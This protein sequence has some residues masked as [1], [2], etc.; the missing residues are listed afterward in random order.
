ME[1][2]HVRYFLAVAEEENF[3]RAAVR[4]GIGQPPLSQQIRALE[5]ELGTPLFRRLPHGAQLTEAGE[6]FLPEAR[7]MLA[8]A[9]RAVRAAQRAARGEVGQL[10][11]GFTGSAAFCPLVPAVVRAFRRAH[12]E[13]E[14]SLEEANTTT[15]LERLAGEELDAAFIRPGRAN[16]QG[17]RV[18]SLLE[19]P[20]WAVLPSS[21]PLAQAGAVALAALAREPFVLFP[22]SAGAS[23]FDEVLSACQRAGFEP[24]LVQEVSQLASVG[25][26][27]AAELGVSVVPASMAQVRVP[28]VEYLPLVGDAPVARLALATRLDEDSGGVR[29]FVTL[30]EAEGRRGPG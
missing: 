8:Q 21:H 1:L 18:Y 15:L 20:M 26:L 3:T 24:N 22:R 5:R 28:G 14:F 30:A 7:A 11:V 19:E 4:V 27:V 13:V 6:A 25:N 17:V 10:R 12:P 23:L 9:E 16:P 29:Q 2:R